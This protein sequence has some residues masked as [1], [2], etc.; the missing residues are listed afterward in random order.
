MVSF[1]VP[2]GVLPH[3]SV[4]VRM[5]VSVGQA[6]GLDETLL[7]AGTGISV[8]DLDDENA[9]IWPDQE[10]D[11]ARNLLGH[12][13]DVP[14][15]GVQTARHATIGKGGMVGL[16]ALV[17]PTIGDVL[18][19][20][21][22]YQDLVSVAARYSLEDRGDEVAIVVDGAAV[23]EDVRDF[24]VEREVAFIFMAGELLDVEIPVLG[25]EMQVSAERGAELA[26][27]TP[28]DR[29]P[30]LFERP[31]N[32]VRLPRAFLDHP[33]PQA[34]SRTASAIERQCREALRH[35]L[36]SS[37]RLTAKVRERLLSDPDRMPSMVEVAAELHVTVRTLRRRLAEEGATF[38]GLLNNVREIKAAELL[39]TSA[40]VE[41]VARR[42]GYA[43]TANFTHAFTRW[44]GMSPRAY[45]QSV[46]RK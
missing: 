45:R 41:D 20:T 15:L 33:M 35:L 43:E 11:V 3:S 2:P 4:S 39:R 23:P 12:L 18:S 29:H 19:I 40:T 24:F 5:M 17:S 30:I 14:G 1:G 6:H 46:L 25:V 32:L 16:A 28:F 13:G 8:G 10:F 42:L 22:R 31:R 9:Q 36:G 38:R 27:L 21:V 34:D 26:A 44:R 37:W 7:L